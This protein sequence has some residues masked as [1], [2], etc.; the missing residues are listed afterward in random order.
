VTRAT[1][2]MLF[3]GNMGYFSDILDALAAGNQML[4]YDLPCHSSQLLKPLDTASS[5]ISKSS[6]DCSRR[7]N[8]CLRFHV[9][10][11]EF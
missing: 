6:T 4:L 11:N 10:L 3:D 2:L 5:A 1:A 8:E 7:F 9:F